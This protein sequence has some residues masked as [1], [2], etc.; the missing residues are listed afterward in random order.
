[1][2]TGV[3]AFGR[4]QGPLV[5]PPPPPPPPGRSSY[6]AS[7]PPSSSSSVVSA[8]AHLGFESLQQQQQL[9][10]RQQQLQQLR[11]PEQENVGA[12]HCVVGGR[13][14]P[15]SYGVPT[16]NFL[17]NLPHDY[18]RLLG[19]TKQNVPDLEQKQNCIHQAYGQFAMQAAQHQQ[20]T[21]VNTTSEKV[22]EFGMMGPPAIDQEILVKNFKMQEKMLAKAGNQTQDLRCPDSVDHSGRGEKHNEQ[23]H[24]HDDQKNELKTPPT[25]T[26]QFTPINMIRPLQFLQSQNVSNNQLMLAQLQVMQAWV[27]E[28]NIDL[29][30][31]DNANLIAAQLLPILQSNRLA[32]TQKTNFC[33]TPTKESCFP[34]SKLEVVSSFANENSAQENSVNNLSGQTGMV[35]NMVSVLPNSSNTPMQ[36]PHPVQTLATQNERSGASAEIVGSSGSVVYCPQRSMSSSQSIDLSNDNKSSTTEL[37]QMQSIR[38]SQNIGHPTSLFDSTSCEVAG[39]RVLSLRGSEQAGLQH[40][41]FTKQQL[42]VLKAQ[43]LAFRRL[44]REHALPLEVLQ[45][46]IP[47]PL[48]SQTQVAQ[49]STKMTNKEENMGG[50][51][52]R[53]PKRNIPQ[54]APLSEGHILPKEWSVGCNAP[55]M[56]NVPVEAAATRE[57]AGEITAKEGPEIYPVP[58]KSEQD[59][60]RDSSFK[61]ENDSEKGNSVASTNVS[62]DVGH[63]KKPVMENVSLSSNA[64]KYF[65]PLF[66]LPSFNKNYDILGLTSVNNSNNFTLVYDIKEFLYE[67]GKQLLRKKRMV[68]LRKLNNLLALNLEMKRIKPDLTLRLRIEEKK[69][70]L[71]DI[72]SRLRDEIDEQQQ[73]ILALPDRPYRKFIRQCECQRQ[74][75]MRQ[76]QQLQKKTREKQ[77]KSIFQWRKKFLETHWDIR[78]TRTTR[79]RGVDKYHER[80]LREFSKNKDD[81]HSK[82]L[83]A[84]KN[85]DV[86]RYREML[87]EQ[88][89]GIPG[90]AAH[91]Y[92]VLSSFLSQKSIFKN[93]EIRL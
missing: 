58:V 41:I 19:D 32:G 92:T 40:F 43:I 73:D 85:N 17:R 7:V 21:P 90:D 75:L 72:Q 5:A 12:V 77:L 31:P 60:D 71:L 84:L 67:E 18:T 27:M 59:V 89:T 65:G 52:E 26:G 53:N 14:F 68:Y 91:R 8:P 54:T 10:L 13:N 79:N 76:V 45:A 2:Q 4:G 57:D 70:S 6:S 93:L 35:R 74:E 50:V 39:S 38:H 87:I 16:S 61:G 55:L 47:P 86:D 25:A 28:C 42:H 11:K 88:Q 83:E 62:V 51:H 49:L 69:L 81:D 78:D 44:K 46:I 48:D 24:M 82:R 56:T 1:M 37:L 36:H 63:V 30:I 80:M 64:K 15:S 34:T 23:N 20:R 66:D 29:T 9:A 33:S 3:G 22:T